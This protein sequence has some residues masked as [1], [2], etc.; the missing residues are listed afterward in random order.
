MKEER[1]DK[2]IGHV[3]QVLSTCNRDDVVTLIKTS[4][5]KILN[6]GKFIGVN[7]FRL[8]DKLLAAIT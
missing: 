4:K 1:L 5:D 6:I 3:L 2:F 8:G 7:Y